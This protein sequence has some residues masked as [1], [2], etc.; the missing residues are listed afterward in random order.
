M[1]AGVFPVSLASFLKLLA[2]AALIAAAVPAFAA[3]KIVAARVWPAQEYTRVTWESARSVKHQMFF[4]P[5]PDRLVVDLEGVELDAEM[6]ALPSKVG[7]N[8]PY[9]QA[10]RVGLNRPNVVRVVFDLRAEV[11]PYLFPLAPAGEYRHRLVLDLYPAKPVDP[12]LALIAPRPDPV[13]EMAR[14]P[15]PAVTRP[16]ATCPCC[17]SCVWS[18]RQ[19]RCLAVPLQ[20]QAPPRCRRSRP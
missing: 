10:V 3:E 5:S 9:I 14:A 11:K 15:L 20:R 1:H 18:R 6:K 2:V 7:A 4:V 8:D 16:A 19:S 12:L 17:R 13:G